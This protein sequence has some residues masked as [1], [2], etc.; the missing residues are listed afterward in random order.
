MTGPIA[1]PPEATADQIPMANTRSLGSVNVWRIIESVGGIIMAAP[2]AKNT[3]EAM[4]SGALGENAA[5]SEAAAKT[6]RP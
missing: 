1:A 6:G 3:R 5:H 2:T 4:S